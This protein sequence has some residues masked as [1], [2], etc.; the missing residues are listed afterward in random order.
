MP[1]T[2]K[3]LDAAAPPTPAP[4]GSSRMNTPGQHRR[5]TAPKPSQSKRFGPDVE[6]LRAVAGHER[7]E[8]RSLDTSGRDEATRRP[9][10]TA[11]HRRGTVESDRRAGGPP[12]RMPGNPPHGL[13]CR[14][15]RPLQVLA[16]DEPEL[17]PRAPRP[18][19]A[20]ERH[21]HRRHRRLHP[22][23][24]AGG[25]QGKARAG[26]A[27]PVSP[28]TGPR[29]SRRGTAPG[30][31][32]ERADHHPVHA[33][34]GDL[35]DL[36][37]ARQDPE[38]PSPDLHPGLRRDGPGDR[39]PRADRQ[40]QLRRAT[41]PRARLPP[42]PRAHPRVGP[43]VVPR[44]RPHLDPLVCRAR[45]EVGLR[46]HRRVLRGPRGAHLRGR[47]GPL[48]RPAD[49]LAGLLP[50]PFSPRLELRRPLAGEAGARGVRG[51]T[52]TSTTSPCAGPWRRARDTGARSSSS[53]RRASTTWT[54]TGA[55]RSDSRRPRRAST[56]AGARCAASRSPSA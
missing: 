1:A 55:A 34:G 47:D 39:E 28:A 19:G 31:L 40:P 23:R 13:L 21:R 18:L 29:A 7:T 11:E 10:S 33:V 51:S 15:A 43:R 36:Q 4:A 32:P 45:V 14:P 41:D 30:R 26:R 56:T 3:P 46:R 9:A 5:L 22:P 38:N 50:G 54:A 35:H 48:F 24:L 6:H 27:G 49:E 20:Q 2:T 12:A 25:D 17:R 8:G 16:G 44:A 52:P 42:P 53:R 37:E